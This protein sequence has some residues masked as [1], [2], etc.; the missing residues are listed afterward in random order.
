MS[1]TLVLFDVDGTLLTGGGVGRRAMEMAGQRVV[2]PAFTLEGVELAGRL[3]PLIFGDAVRALA[4][5]DAHARH[6]AFRQAYV[7]ALGELFLAGARCRALAGVRPLLQRLRTLEGVALGLVSGNY[8]ETGRMKLE[9][10][11][12]PQ[13]WFVVAAWGSDAAGRRDLP[14]VAMGRFAALGGQAVAPGRVVVVGDTPY[15]V[16]AARANGCA[17]V[18]VASGPVY[19]A[20]SLKVHRPD[21]LLPDLAGV[22]AF[23]EWLAGRASAR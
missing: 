2:D 15:D 1:V 13:D 8:P 19:D 10:A 6:A 20:Q 3:D 11:G 4:R 7:E 5:G 16:D 23:V 22:D 9:S 17:S 12:L 18:A 21:L 14:R